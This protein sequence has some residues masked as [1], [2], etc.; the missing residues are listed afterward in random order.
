MNS[1]SGF[2]TRAVHRAHKVGCE[3][4]TSLQHGDHQQAVRIGFGDLPGQ[5]RR[6]AGQW[7]LRRTRCENVGGHGHSRT[8]LRWS[9]STNRTWM[10][11][12]L[13]GGSAKIVLNRV[14]SRAFS[15]F[16]SRLHRPGIDFLKVCTSYGQPDR[17]DRCCCSS[18]TF[19]IEPSTT[20]TRLPVF[21]FGE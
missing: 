4:E 8:I 21:Y 16:G 13:A 9:R 15:V 7:H 17:G 2:K 5:R 11:D 20:S 18:R 19:R 3:D 6:P 10:S 14:S 1:I 12:A